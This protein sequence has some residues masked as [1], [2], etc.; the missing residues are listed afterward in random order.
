[1]YHEDSEVFGTIR[2]MV[3]RSHPF[4]LLRFGDGEGIF[5]CGYSDFVKRYQ[6]SSLKH[7]GQ[8][9]PL[10]YRYKIADDILKAFIHAD[11]VGL[12]YDFKGQWW[13]FA[14]AQFLRIDK[15]VRT[16]PAYKCGLNIHIELERSGVL[17]ELIKGREVV[18][19]GS[20]DIVKRLRQF[21]AKQ[22]EW[23]KIAGQYR[24]ERTKPRTPFFMQL[25]HIERELTRMDLEGKLCLL[26]AGVAG[27]HLGIIMRDRGGMVVDIG[28]VMD[29]WTGVMSRT[30]IKTAQQ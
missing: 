21:G 11:I 16:Y 25:E 10:N 8:V 22:V 4:A 28:S 26:G 7:W 24:F 5:C 27:K 17:S 14:L 30:W 3:E 12:P 15:D 18:V 13:Q 1:M 9:P 29:L 23:V 19:V 20:R 2:D 6:Q